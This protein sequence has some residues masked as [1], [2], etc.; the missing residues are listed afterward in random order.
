M[1]KIRSHI[2]FKTTAFK[3]EVKATL[4]RFQNAKAGLVRFVTN[5]EHSNEVWLSRVALLLSE[6]SRS[7]GSFGVVRKISYTASRMFYHDQHI[8]SA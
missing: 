8:L 1:I 6:I 4:F 5:E 2:R 7:I 3:S